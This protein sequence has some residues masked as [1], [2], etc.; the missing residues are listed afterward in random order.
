MAPSLSIIIPTH[1]R[2]SILAECL[3]CLDRQTIREQLEII[4]VQDGKDDKTTKLLEQLSAHWLL[5]DGLPKPM[6][7]YF[8]IPK[9]QQGAARNFG[10][11]KASAPLVLFIGDDIFLAPDACEKHLFVHQSNQPKNQKTNKLHITKNEPTNQQTND[12]AVL[13]HTTWDPAL[14]M[15]PVM[16]YLETS[17]WQFGYPALEPYRHMLIPTQRQ[18][19]FT[20]TSHISI[21][22]PIAKQ[23][24]FRE[25]VTLY[26]W[27]DMEWGMRL[28]EVGIRLFYQP[29]AKAFHHHPMTLEQSLKRVETL[30]KSAVITERMNPGLSVTPK[31]WKKLIYPAIALL[32]TMRGRHAKAFLKGI[33]S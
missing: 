10:V 8:D 16:K 7:E 27:E 31:S 1:K 20:Y 11:Q 19:S 22:A 6:L 29:D 24:Q 32:P 28:R 13:G 15:T 14:I 23:I 26:G 30:G 2:A 25:D 9:S 18:E 21:P 4:V 17:G 33:R 12:I 3:A 5:K